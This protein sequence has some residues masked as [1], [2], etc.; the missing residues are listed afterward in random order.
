MTLDGGWNHQPASAVLS[1]YGTQNKYLSEQKRPKTLDFLGRKMEFQ[2]SIQEQTPGWKARLG[3][4][5]A[6]IHMRKRS[7]FE[8]ENHMIPQELGVD[9]FEAMHPAQQ[10]I[11]IAMC[12]G[13]TIDPDQYAFLT[14][15]ALQPGAM[16][17]SG[18]LGAESTELI[19]MTCTKWTAVFRAQKN[20][21]AAITM[22]RMV[23]AKYTATEL[24]WRYGIPYDQYMVRAKRGISIVVNTFFAAF[25]KAITSSS[26][27]F[28][29]NNAH[30]VAA[31]AGLGKEYLPFVG[32]ATEPEALVAAIKGCSSEGTQHNS[33]LW[34][35]NARIMPPGERARIE[36][37]D[38][39]VKGGGILPSSVISPRIGPLSCT[40][41]GGM[42]AYPVN[43]KTDTLVF[44]S[45]TR[46]TD[47]IPFQQSKHSIEGHAV[48]SLF[49]GRK[50]AIGDIYGRDFAQYPSI[51]P[52]ADTEH[53][54]I[55]CGLPCTWSLDLPEAAQEYH[56][57][58][59]NRR[60]VTF[61]KGGGNH[62]KGYEM[63]QVLV[64]TMGDF[65]HG[66][67]VT[68]QR[69]FSVMEG[70]KCFNVGLSMDPS[71]AFGSALAAGESF[72]PPARDEHNNVL[73]SH[74]NW[75]GKNTM[76]P[77]VISDVL[78]GYRGIVAADDDD[79]DNAEEGQSGSPAEFFDIVERLKTALAN[80]LVI[81]TPSK[82][83]HFFADFWKSRAAV[84]DAWDKIY[85]AA[86]IGSPLA[87][88]NTSV[89]LE[90]KAAA[91]ILVSMKSF[92]SKRVFEVTVEGDS[93]IL[94]MMTMDFRSMRGEFIKTLSGLYGQGA[95]N[96]R[97]QAALMGFMF[98]PWTQALVL[99]A[100]KN[101]GPLPFGYATL[102][103]REFETAPVVGYTSNMG[104]PSL[105]QSVGTQLT[106][107]PWFTTF[108]TT[109]AIKELQRPTENA[110]RDFRS[111]LRLS[112]NTLATQPN[113][114]VTAGVVNLSQMLNPGARPEEVMGAVVHSDV[115]ITKY[116]A[117]K[118]EQCF[119]RG[120]NPT[121]GNIVA[122]IGLILAL[123]GEDFRSQQLTAL[124]ADDA[125]TAKL[126]S[127]TKDAL[128]VRLRENPG[129]F[130]LPC[131]YAIPA[132]NAVPDVVFSQ[133]D[134]YFFRPEDPTEADQ[135]KFCVNMKV[136]W[137]DAES[138]TAHG[139]AGRLADVYAKQ[140]RRY[141]S[142]APSILDEALNQNGS[143]DGKNGEKFVVQSFSD[144]LAPKMPE[145][146]ANG[147]L[148]WLH[149][150]SW[151]PLG[152][153]FFGG[154]DS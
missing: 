21:M 111:K 14:S 127:L 106:G 115:R 138:G 45:A 129:A 25:V 41:F 85:Q 6:G 145:H 83:S 34:P 110:I 124:M 92:F 4:L 55:T 116:E 7:E 75:L 128:A 50:T 43:D 53:G 72:Y 132:R 8:D 56:R 39:M 5:W 97:S 78:G 76:T 135:G 146:T 9:A 144:K 103:R 93:V 11:I 104:D 94:S 153:S 150:Y 151:R 108:G 48:A 66:L 35:A 19:A 28:I 100:I 141:V 101:R 31:C 3:R 40:D 119:Q 147:P 71:D 142:R 140:A 67:G 88:Q 13:I 98:W 131:S 87:D 52:Y 120:T 51:R 49:A 58:Q 123:P 27:D 26:C 69:L 95:T 1:G 15:M 61:S 54:S 62:K 148:P 42:K 99:A 81:H 68:P 113:I 10:I 90:L 46:K 130:I 136:Y 126:L 23:W 60:G 96:D 74:D 134:A 32:M 70:L 112:D 137:D 22:P 133:D 86:E 149:P 2:T 47:G 37:F 59:I 152:S 117:R 16:W 139:L 33:L 36:D 105:E 17:V 91:A 20:S 65:T 118:P 84:R 12:S 102:I 24:S 30:V 77:G 82:D 73:P 125:E 121:E 154:G 79:D 109:E 57:E 64:D 63:P 29:N 114:A 80:A 44:W 18:A 122:S 107:S 143:V 38:V 89:T